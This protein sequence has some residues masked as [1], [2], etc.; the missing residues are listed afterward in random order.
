MKEI[1]LVE[2]QDRLRKASQELAD[3]WHVLDDI[4]WG[5][6]TVKIEARD[7]LVVRTEQT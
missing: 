4:R 3:I 1:Y 5:R 7:G 2:L 6:A